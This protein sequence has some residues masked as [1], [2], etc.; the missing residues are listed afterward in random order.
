M[1]WYKSKYDGCGALLG[2][3]AL[4]AQFNYFGS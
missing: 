3:A 4:I 1:A 2:G